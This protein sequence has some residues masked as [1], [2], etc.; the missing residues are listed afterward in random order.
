MTVVTA[1]D[2]TLSADLPA[3]AAAVP[4][5]LAGIV[6]GTGPVAA[7]PDPPPIQETPAGT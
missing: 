1:G 6:S 3:V 4:A 7:S 5:W 2:H